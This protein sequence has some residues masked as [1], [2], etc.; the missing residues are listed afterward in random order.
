MVSSASLY[1]ESRYQKFVRGLPQTIFYCPACKGDRRGRKHCAY[2]A[3]RGKLSDDSV[4][5]L[6]SRRL[7]PAFRAETG[8]FHGAG[9]EDVD[10]RMLGR[11]RPF[12]FEVVGPR[13]DDVDL[14]A[15]LE[16]FHQEAGDRVRCAPFVVVDRKRVAALKEAQFDKQYRI[17]VALEGA[18][19]AAT[20]AAFAGQICTI[21]QRTP[22][23]VA[24]RR[25][26]LVRDRRV[27][28]LAARSLDLDESGA[29]L[30]IDVETAHGTY[31][32]EWVSGDEGRTTPSFADLVGVPARCARLDVLEILDS[33]SDP[34]P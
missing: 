28:I 9:R 12:V 30:E 26:D 11:G 15:L 14:V 31:V 18:V 7:L 24:H 16:R 22:Q 29:S 13:R 34:A 23:R 3:G 27:T 4:Q 6:L 19:V 20:V 5:E 10:V 17:G 33:V 2:C 21:A 25:G 32:K 1:L 8:K